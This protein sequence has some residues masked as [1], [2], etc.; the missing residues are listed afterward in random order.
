MKTHTAKLKDPS[1]FVSFTTKKDFL[2][3]GIDAVIGVKP[4]KGARGGRSEVQTLVF[5]GNRYSAVDSKKMA[6]AYAEDQGLFKIEFYPAKVLDEDDAPGITTVSVGADA[7]AY[8]P[9]ISEVSRYGDFPI[10][11]AKKN[12]KSLSKLDKFFSTRGIQ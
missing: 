4:K 6:E 9:K 10:A 8:K 12:Q 1:E 5:D 11:Q 7:Y 2:A 3:P